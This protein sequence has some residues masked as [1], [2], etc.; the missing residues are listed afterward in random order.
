MSDG[1]HWIHQFQIGILK[2]NL[3]LYKIREYIDWPSILPWTCVQTFLNVH[4]KARSKWRRSVYSPQ[5]WISRI[6]CFTPRLI[7]QTGDFRHRGNTHLRDSFYPPMCSAA[8]ES[9]T[10]GKAQRKTKC[11]RQRT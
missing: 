11:K 9:G 2:T 4:V 8:A 3:Q 7:M 6:D 5:L 10:T 1:V